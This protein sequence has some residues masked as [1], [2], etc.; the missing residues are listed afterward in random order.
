MVREARTRF[1]EGRPIVIFPEGTRSAPGE[2]LPYQPGV[3]ALALASGVP[4]VPV[5]TDSG[6]SWG[7]RAFHKRQGVI[8]L[9]VLPPL[10][11]GLARPALMQALEAA[12]ETETQRLLA[13]HLPVDKSG[14]EAWD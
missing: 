8:H 1:A 4:V 3:A 14:E 12:I 13:Q 5:A 10:P 11:S 7:R 9:S 2:R 6:L